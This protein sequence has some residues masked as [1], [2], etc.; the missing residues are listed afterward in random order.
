MRVTNTVGL[1][2]ETNKI[3]KEVMKGSPVIITYR[4]K[5]AASLTALTEDD[6]EDFIL[7]NSPKIRKMIVQAEKDIRA[8]KVTSLAD[9]LAKLDE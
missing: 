1:K 8:G 5:P 6:L 9:Y 2:N 7:E 3:L 4:G